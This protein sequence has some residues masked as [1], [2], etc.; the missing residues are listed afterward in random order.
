MSEEQ[1]KQYA[2]QIIIIRTIGYAIGLLKGM[3]ANSDAITELEENFDYIV[4]EFTVE[5]LEKKE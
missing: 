2:L 5:P 3:N 4:N 1:R